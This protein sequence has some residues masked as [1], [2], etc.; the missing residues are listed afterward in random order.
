MSSLW[1]FWY[2]FV[3]F[4]CFVG[5]YLAHRVAQAFWHTHTGT[6][7]LL[8]FALTDRSGELRMLEYFFSKGLLGGGCQTF[9]KLRM[10]SLPPSQ[11]GFAQQG[12][13]S[14]G[15]SGG[16]PGDG[17][18]GFHSGAAAGGGPESFGRNR[19]KD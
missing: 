13:S 18:F 4:V 12:V 7:A 15:S 11:P 10:G 16:G 9:G 2:S 3:R 17:S 14:G 5:W 8:Y 6:L 1:E 19:T